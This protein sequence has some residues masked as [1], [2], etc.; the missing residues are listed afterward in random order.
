[1]WID[2]DNWY[3]I[4]RARWESFTSLVLL[5]S[6]LTSLSMAHQSKQ[7]NFP[8]FFLES[9]KGPS[10]VHLVN[11]ICVTSLTWY[12]SN[13]V[14]QY[15]WHDG[16][17]MYHLWSFSTNLRR[18]T[19]SRWM[20]E[21]SRNIFREGFCHR[22]KRRG[23]CVTLRFCPAVTDHEVSKRKEQKYPCETKAYILRLQDF[24]RPTK[25]WFFTEIKKQKSRPVGTTL[26]DAN[27]ELGRQAS[28]ITTNG[29]FRSHSIWKSQWPT[30][31]AASETKQRVEKVE[32]N[33]KSIFYRPRIN[34][35]H[36]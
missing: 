16:W 18:K 27:M 9:T 25:E 13:S 21:T 8:S 14:E 11:Q 17:C 20:Q 22:W 5:L 35:R 15:Y 31:V 30:Y 12:Q 23:H 29:S 32:L 7:R 36:L 10:A 24:H 3:S 34:R 4:E 6:L 33:V 26:L 2:L 19:S 28:L 1:M